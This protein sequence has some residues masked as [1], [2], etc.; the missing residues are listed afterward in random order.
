MV[1]VLVP[2]I[3]FAISTIEK[4]FFGTLYNWL[5]TEI[6]TRARYGYSYKYYKDGGIINAENLANT[7]GAV[8]VAFTSGQTSDPMHPLV[9]VEDGWK[10]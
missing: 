3:V 10:Q 9:K 4:R 5:G 2:I 1:A 8:P 7:S 6:Q